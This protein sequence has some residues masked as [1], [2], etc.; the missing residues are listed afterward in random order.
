MLS[1]KQ[2]LLEMPFMRDTES[3]LPSHRIFGDDDFRDRM[4][5]IK[6][7]EKASGVVHKPFGKIGPYTLLHAPPT[8]DWPQHSILVRHGRKNVGHVSF[9]MRKNHK[10]GGVHV[11]E[12]MDATEIPRFLRQHSGRRSLVPDLPA[13]VYMETAKHFGMPIVSGTR[14]TMG[15][16]NIWDTISRY[17]ERVLAVNTNS[18]KTIRN[19]NPRVHGREVYDE[20][21]GGTNWVLIHHPGPQN[22]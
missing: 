2:F 15:G 11:P 21:G 3:D 14:Q 10:F 9:T 12:H 7:T 17:T 6:Q 20:S 1:F 19:Y 4:V 18:N 5:A 16:K 13:R 22:V 8:G